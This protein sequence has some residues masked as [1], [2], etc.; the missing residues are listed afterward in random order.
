MPINLPYNAPLMVY[1]A[2]IKCSF[3][4]GFTQIK[5]IICST[6]I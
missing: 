3:L 1:L 4:Y 5:Q 6:H 2:Q